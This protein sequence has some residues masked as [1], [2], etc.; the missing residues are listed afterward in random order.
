M[1]HTLFLVFG[2]NPF[3]SLFMQSLKGFPCSTPK[4][5]NDATQWG[6]ILLI[7]SMFF[8]RVH[9]NH[10]H[11]FPILGPGF[12]VELVGQIT[13]TCIVVLLKCQHYCSQDFWFQDL[14]CQ[15]Y[16]LKIFKNNVEDF[17]WN[18][19]LKIFSPPIIFDNFPLKIFGVLFKDLWW[20]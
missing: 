7:L 11:F 14:W 2:E 18:L 3:W 15:A 12:L 1:C 16:P 5:L 10:G 20:P 17:W 13:N 9:L 6:G 8:T 4:A 19:T